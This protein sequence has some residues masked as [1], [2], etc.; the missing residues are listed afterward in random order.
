M[1]ATT[2]AWHI[3][4]CVA[5]IV[6]WSVTVG[7]SAPRWPASW[8]RRDRWPLTPTRWD[9]P[10]NYRRLGVTWLIRHLPEGGTWFGGQS[11]SALPGRDRAAL[12]AYAAEARRAEWVHLL[13]ITS[14]LALPWWNPWW[15]S[16]AF[17]AVLLVANV[18]FLVILR[19]NRVRIERILAR[20]RPTEGSP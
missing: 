12:E 4:G 6:V 16:L 8:V 1:T 14:W 5:V 17:L 3:A 15:L 7:A 9:T 10:E 11:K 2:L 19:Y 20:S 13:S 18:P